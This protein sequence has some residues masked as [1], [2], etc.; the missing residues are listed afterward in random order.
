MKCTWYTEVC[1][2]Y[3]EVCT[4]YTEVCC[5]ILKYA[6][7]ILLIV[8]PRCVTH[9]HSLQSWC[10]CEGL[11]REEDTQ[12]HWGDAATSYQFV[13]TLAAAAYSSSVLKQN[14]NL[15]KLHSALS[16]FLYLPSLPLNLSL[17]PSSSSSKLIS[18]H[19]MWLR[20]PTM[21]ISDHL[22]WPRLPQSQIT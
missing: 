7:D 2:W 9:F 5:D 16:K 18:D 14:K 11:G 12:E 15:I 13:D 8:I 10:M 6:R 17:C 22:M 1:T 21:Y 19:L 3:T 20:L 4:W